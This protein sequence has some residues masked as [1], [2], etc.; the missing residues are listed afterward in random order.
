MRAD[1]LIPYGISGV[2]KPMPY[3]LMDKAL[4]MVDVETAVTGGWGMFDDYSHH[5]ATDIGVHKRRHGGNKTGFSHTYLD[6]SHSMYNKDY[7]M[8]LMQWARDNKRLVIICGHKPVGELTGNPNEVLISDI[9]DICEYVQNNNMKF[10][11]YS[12]L[13]GIRQDYTLQKPTSSYMTYS[14]DFMV[15]GLIEITS[16]WDSAAGRFA[17]LLPNRTYK[18]YRSDDAAGTNEVVVSGTTRQRTCVAD[19]G[20]K[21]LRC[22]VTTTDFIEQS[23]EHFVPR[24]YINP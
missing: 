23:Y 17:S 6:A 3:A 1:G 19:D 5:F 2:G 24:K 4:K 7:I 12:E 22:G 18:W 9:V 20:G 16:E 13:N 15:G 8:G 14:G 10:Y 21:W 11:T